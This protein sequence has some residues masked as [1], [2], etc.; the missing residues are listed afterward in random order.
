MEKRRRKT[1]LTNLTYNKDIKQNVLKKGLTKSIKPITP[2]EFKYL[3]YANLFSLIKEKDKGL[4]TNNPF[5]LAK[6]YLKK[7]NSS[8]SKNN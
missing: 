3:T 1:N 5:I 4:P 6:R 7:K 2:E 8:F